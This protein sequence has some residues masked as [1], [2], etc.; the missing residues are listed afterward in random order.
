LERR[1]KRGACTAAVLLLLAIPL[2]VA[3]GETP[4]SDR[5]AIKVADQ[6]MDALGGKA[7]WNA[8]GGLRWT[9]EV[10]G[11]DTVRAPRRHAWD[12][13]TN[14]HRVEGTNRQG[15]PFVYIDHL[16]SGKGMAWMNGVAM[17]GDTVPKL[18]KRAHSMW[19]NDTYWMLM[20]Y[21]L[22]DP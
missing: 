5:H 13:H 6:V 9:F 4:D 2:A 1:A 3:R 8:L 15:V 20:P 18:M 7:R 11:N 17:E 14:W 10:S 12:R 21:K 16:D 22:R 19:T